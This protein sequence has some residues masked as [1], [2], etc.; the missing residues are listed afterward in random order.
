MAVIFPPFSG[1][2]GSKGVNLTYAVS[3]SYS[4]LILMSR[5]PY[6]DVMKG[7]GRV[8]S[9]FFILDRYILKDVPF[10]SG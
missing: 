9:V 3:F 8:P 4:V 5:Q 6:M 1:W 7:P 2:F 10:V